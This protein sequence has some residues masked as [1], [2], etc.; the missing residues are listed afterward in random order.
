MQLSLC[1][2]KPVFAHEAWWAL[3]LHTSYWHRTKEE[4]LRAPFQWLSD[5]KVQ[6]TFNTCVSIGHSC[7][8]TMRIV[9]FSL[10]SALPR[11]FPLVLIK[12]FK[13]QMLGHTSVS[14]PYSYFDC[15][16]GISEHGSI[17]SHSDCRHQGS[18]EKSLPT[19]EICWLEAEMLSPLFVRMGDMAR[20]TPGALWQQKILLLACQGSLMPSTELQN[21][22]KCDGIYLAKIYFKLI[23]SLISVINLIIPFIA[24]F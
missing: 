7:L 6:C 12:C 21:H 4:L 16:L 3:S 8:S 13:V 10:H 18:E 11:D 23:G 14:S 22:M 1:V 15:L 17:M 24:L 20:S 2:R 19:T 5:R 9:Q